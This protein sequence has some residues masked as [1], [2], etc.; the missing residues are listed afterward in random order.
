MPG[1]VVES[2]ELII[3]RMGDYE[4]KD[5]IFNKNTGNVIVTAF[6]SDI[7]GNTHL[8]DYFLYPFPKCYADGYY[9][10]RIQCELFAF[11]SEYW[12]GYVPEC[13]KEIA[14]KV[15]QGKVNNVLVRYKIK[16]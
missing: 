5:I 8:S 7:H 12:D 9:Y 6:D 16:A 1:S 15:K 4:G 13:M 14:E 3:R 2:S 11:P 10:G